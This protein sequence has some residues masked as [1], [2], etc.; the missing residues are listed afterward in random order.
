MGMH[1]FYRDYIWKKGVPLGCGRLLDD[2][3][4]QLPF[5]YK[6][7]DDP[8]RKRF[9]IERYL[10]AA[11]DQVI[12]DSQLLDF[13]RLKPAEQQGWQREIIQQTANETSCLIRNQEERMLYLEHLRFES[14][15]CR[16][17]RLSTPQGTPLSIH[18]LFYTALNDSFDG[19]LLYDNNDH[20]VLAKRYAVGPTGEF[21]E[22]LE[23]RWDHQDPSF[24]S[25]WH[26]SHASTAAV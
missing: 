1:P 22:L 13:R 4:L 26:D 19:I 8:Y 5:A 20:L 18:R 16:E 10:G 6:I 24:L 23:E 3:I 17:C 15:Y 7:V 2:Q 9:S 14:Q 25:R 12:Y 11:F 21:T